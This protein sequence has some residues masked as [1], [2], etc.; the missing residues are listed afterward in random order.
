[1][2]LICRS[3]RHRFIAAMAL[4]M[5]LSLLLSG[6]ALAQTPPGAVDVDAACEGAPD[7]GFG[8]IAG[9]TF[10]DEIACAAWY[11]ITEGTAG[12]DYEPF[13]G[14]TRW[15][16]A[17]F[18]LRFARYAD[19]HVDVDLPAAATD[20]GFTDIGEHS[21][22]A[23][24]AIN[25]LAEID[26]VNG[27]TATTYEPQEIIRRDQMASFVN[28]LQE[29]LTG[30]AFSGGDA[31]ASSVHFDD[32]PDSNVHSVNIA[33]LASVG[34]VQGK[35][36]G[37]YDPQ[38][39]VTRQ[40]MS[41]FL[42]RAVQ[43]NVNDD[44]VPP[45]DGEVPEPGEEA[46]PGGGGGGGGGSAPE[47]LT[48]TDARV[49]EGGGALHT[50]DASDVV[51]LTFSKDMAEGDVGTWRFEATDDDG[52][53]FAIDCAG[54]AVACVVNDSD[55]DGGDV[56]DL[57]TIRFGGGLAGVTDLNAGTG[58]DTPN[59]PATIVATSASVDDESGDPVDLDAS[60][61][62]I[63]EEGALAA[64]GDNP[65]A[66]L[67]FWYSS[68]FG[69]GDFGEDG[70]E[71]MFINYD[72]D[73]AL[74]VGGTVTLDEDGDTTTTG[75][76]NTYTCAAAPAAAGEVNCSATLYQLQIHTT[77]ATVTTTV[78]TGGV[79]VVVATGGVTDLA[80]NQD[81]GFPVVFN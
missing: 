69:N 72:E 33:A 51:Q 12:G 67:A 55:T 35:G 60:A 13:T 17:L 57:L 11:G 43:V 61:D 28:R 53:L 47:L 14:V 5:T 65:M 78:I 81:E 27:T 30:A 40:E 62:V 4:A 19:P 58:D 73:I 31:D 3:L 29:W 79:S 80:G 59:L 24:D 1:M 63:I 45:M 7:P 56:D 68:M 20:Q 52:D 9:T 77:P 16:M 46:P 23:R 25:I 71:S 66:V 6:T 75:D 15:Q 32:V 50:L 10:E 70:D 76:Q 18:V 38:G 44:V 49:H 8:D 74:G 48:I 22:E 42:V 37:R 54:A 21:A 39:P 64:D 36:S 34:I 41:G 26:V 2:T